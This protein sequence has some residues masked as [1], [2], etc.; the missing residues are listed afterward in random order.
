WPRGRR[1]V[2][3]IRGRGCTD[4]VAF[5]QLLRDPRILTSN[6]VGGSQR[7]KS[8]QR[9]VTQIAD[10]SGHDIKPGRER[11]RMDQLAG[12]RIGSRSIGCGGTGG[13]INWHGY[14]WAAFER[15]PIY[16]IQ[17]R[18]RMDNQSARLLL[19]RSPKRAILRL[20]AL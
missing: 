13:V 20:R 11:I 15:P 2:V 9:N 19:R 10:R 3:V 7:F 14:G 8:P 4:L 17:F 5:K 1:V 6:E 12:D 16:A 18:Q